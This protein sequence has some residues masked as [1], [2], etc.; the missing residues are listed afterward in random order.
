[1]SSLSDAFDAPV[2]FNEHGLE[3]SLPKLDLDDHAAWCKELHAARKPGVLKLIPGNAPPTERFKMQRAVE[4][5]EP[6]LDSIADLLY[7][8]GG[9]RDCLTRSLRKLGKSPEE[10]LAIV[11]RIPPGRA[12]RLALDVSGLFEKIPPPLIPQ[13]GGNT[14][15]PL[16]QAPG[17][18][19]SPASTP[20]TGDGPGSSSAST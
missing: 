8:P 6:T 3:L 15:D 20:V 7:T 17:S 14:P 9:A 5:D 2:P 10:A 1:M 18:Q 16:A 4:Y 11:K 13:Q 12:Q 19:S